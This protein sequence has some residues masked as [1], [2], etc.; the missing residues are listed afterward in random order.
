MKYQ[1]LATDFDGTLATG[2]KVAAETVAALE[3]LRASGRKLI[4]V[5]GRHLEDLK[6]IFPQILLFERVI[7][8]N[9]AL[10]YRPS[11][12]EMQTLGEPPPEKFLQALSARGVPFKAGHVML[13]THTPYD[14]A[15]LE[16]IG[17]L[18]L[19]WRVIYNKGAVM[20][21]PSGIDKASALKRAL[22]E[23]SLSRH[24]L[25]TI[26]DGEND[27]DFLDL[28]ALAVAVK[29]ALPVLKEKADWVTSQPA[30]AG[31]VELIDRLLELDP[32]SRP[33]LSQRKE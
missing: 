21:L 22:Q 6:Q 19:D 8:E 31:V 25:V 28:G 23:L 27:L 11:P 33:K 7:A 30:G 9:G 13:N 5:T 24:D 32:E 4:L 12:S 10:L 29:N 3:R 15:A 16:V 20:L 18:G 14:Q 2:G 1:T 17:E 26:G